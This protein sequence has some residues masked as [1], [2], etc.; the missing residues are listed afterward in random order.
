MLQLLLGIQLTERDWIK[1]E[2]ETSQMCE[3]WVLSPPLLK[4]G[5]AQE[6]DWMTREAQVITSSQNCF[7][8]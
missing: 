3:H 5:D 8:N 4:Q 2:M 7:D 6:T 1:S